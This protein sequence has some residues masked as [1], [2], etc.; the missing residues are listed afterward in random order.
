MRDLLLSVLLVCAASPN[1]FAEPPRGRSVLEPI[2]GVRMRCAGAVGKQIDANVQDWLLRA[3]ASNPGLLAM[4]ELRDRKPTPNLVPWAGEFVGK[5]LISAIQ[6]LRLSESAEL[7][8]TVRAVVAR[9]LAIRSG[10]TRL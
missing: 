9:P 3:P 1:A 6:S 7:E 5:Y 2:A 4:F 10:V 8:A